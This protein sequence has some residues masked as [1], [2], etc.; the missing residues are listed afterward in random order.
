[1]TTFS[2]QQL[3]DELCHLLRNSDILTT[4]VR[5]VTTASQTFTATAGQT[6]FTLTNTKAKNIRSLT[7]QS[8]AK[9]YIKDYTVAWDTSVITLGTGATLN[10]S[11]V[12]SYDYGTSD[13]IYP[14]YPRD[15]L[16]LTSYPRVGIELTSINTE[17]LGLGGMTHI[18]D[19]V[20]TIFGWVSVNKDSSIAGGYG[21]LT[22][23]NTLM[24]NIR[25]AIRTN[26]KSLYVIN[27]MTPTIIGPLIRGTN[28]KIMQQ[29]QDV[30]IKFK[31]E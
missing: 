13:K 2:I 21:G 14:D 1:M 9:T 15:D 24:Y 28:N 31:T 22:D 8:V 16:T 20:M 23:L 3:R 4:S 17:P 29:S 5:G 25:N 12:V 10:D 27:Y 30:H 19:I 18:S 11:V 7:V 26:A 6:V